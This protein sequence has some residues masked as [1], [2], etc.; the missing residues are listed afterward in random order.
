[1]TDDD[2]VGGVLS[3]ADATVLVAAGEA[4][5]TASGSRA[6]RTI[7]MLAVAAAVVTLSVGCGDES[8]AQTDGVPATL[9]MAVTDL[10]G[11]KELQREFGSL[12]AELEQP[13]AMTTSTPARVLGL[14]PSAVV[15]GAPLDAVAVVRNDTAFQ[16]IAQWRNGRLVHLRQAAVLVDPRVACAS[17]GRRDLAEFTAW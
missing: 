13:V 5:G 11:L 2:R 10:Q 3:A 4:G 7:G 15:V 1:M 14:R 8:E 17:P 12:K 9:R 16:S 6:G